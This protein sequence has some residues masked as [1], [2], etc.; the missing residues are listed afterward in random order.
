MFQK[1]LHLHERVYREMY[2]IRIEDTLLN[3]VINK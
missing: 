1:K 3:K 2:G